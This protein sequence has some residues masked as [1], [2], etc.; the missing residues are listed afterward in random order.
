MSLFVCRLI[1]TKYREVKE[2][3]FNNI[4][5]LHEIFVLNS[6]ENSHTVTAF[7]NLEMTLNEKKN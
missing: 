4:V 6:L 1:R 2:L 3:Y 5:I 7:K